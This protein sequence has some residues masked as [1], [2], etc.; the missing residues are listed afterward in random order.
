MSSVNYLALYLYNTNGKRV[1]RCLFLCSA[2][3]KCDSMNGNVSKWVSFSA[4]SATERINM[5]IYRET[6]APQDKDG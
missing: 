6:S 3:P 4:I 2:L 5:N 1:R